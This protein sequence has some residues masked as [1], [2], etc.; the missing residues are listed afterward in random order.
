MQKKY[1]ENVLYSNQNRNIGLHLTNNLFVEGILLDVK[2]KHIV[3]KTNE[4]IVY[5]AIHQIQALSQNTTD[6][7]IVK[8][9]IPHLVRDDMTDVLIALRYHWVTLNKYN[10]HNFFGVLSCI[11][12]DYIILIHNKELLYVPISHITDISSEVS[13][14]EYAFLNKKEQVTIQQLYRSGLSKESFEIK[15]DN[16]ILE[17]EEVLPSE[18]TIALEV[19]EPT[20]YE[21]AVH[22]ESS[23]ILSVKDNSSIT[24][25]VTSLKSV[26]ETNSLTPALEE[27]PEILPTP[28]TN[29]LEEQHNSNSD[30]ELTFS[31]NPLK[32][33]GKGVLLTAWSTMNSDQS[34][35]ELP[36]ETNRKTKTKTT[37]L[38]N[39]LMDELNS[40]DIQKISNNM[41]KISE[42]KKNK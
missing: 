10:N 22:K 12:E 6:L 28:S 4:N 13:I 17:Q 25:L 20:N 38:S 9:P 15:A 40:E 37:S 2:P 14:N 35:V 31:I 24:D 36:K 39:Q 18:D 1:F 23:S 8:E 11:Y 34:T 26:L 21:K 16:L 27:I 29:H 42:K 19:I 3:L 5:F 32:T 33:K 41:L 30:E 7:S